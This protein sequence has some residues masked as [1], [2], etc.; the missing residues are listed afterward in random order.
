MELEQ[1]LTALRNADA[2]GNVEDAKQLA[3]IARRLMGTPPPKE[4]ESGPK[5]ETGLLAFCRLLG[6][7]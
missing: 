1:V 6:K 5:P 7:K 4:A 2:A 3:Q